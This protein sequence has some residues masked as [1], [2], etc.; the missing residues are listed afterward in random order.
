MIIL[1]KDL[2]TWNALQQVGGPHSRSQDI[3]QDGSAT[4]R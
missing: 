1:F 2:T 3:E 4:S